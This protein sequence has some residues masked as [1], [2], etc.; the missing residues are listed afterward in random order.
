MKLQVDNDSH[1]DDAHDD[2]HDDRGELKVNQ[3]FYLNDVR[4]AVGRQIPFCNK[5]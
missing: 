2:V 4:I 3:K 1:D 5:F